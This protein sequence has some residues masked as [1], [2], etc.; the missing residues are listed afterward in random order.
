MGGVENPSSG[1]ATFWRKRFQRYGHTGWSDPAIYAYDQPERLTLI[2]RMVEKETITRGRAL[3]FGCGSGD[4][5]RLLLSLGF[6]VWGYDP[7]VQPAMH[8][9]GFTYAESCDQITVASGSADLALSV[10]TL[11][12]IL[13]ENE[14]RLALGLISACLKAK[15]VFFMLEYALDCDADRLRL[16]L[17][18]DYQSFRTLARWTELLRQNSL[19]VTGV[20]AVSHPQFCPSRGY[21]AYARSPLWRV[22]RRLVRWRQIVELIDI[23][24]QWQA[25]RLAGKSSGIAGP[26]TSSPLKLIRA[27]LS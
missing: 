10:T 23:L 9:N 8:A 16:G 20:T 26:G 22:R 1:G 7:F 3:D 21:S 15:G 6:E 12:H 13:D 2:K 17:R 18:N 4:F 5:S 27:T 24:L 25:T 19:S 11:D 14:L